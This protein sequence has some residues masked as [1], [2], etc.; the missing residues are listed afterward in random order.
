MAKLEKR[1]IRIEDW[2][3]NI[4]YPAS[5]SSTTSGVISNKASSDPNA[6]VYRWSIYNRF[7]C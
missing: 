6:S 3:G 1:H 5:A 4:Y 2:K 7:K